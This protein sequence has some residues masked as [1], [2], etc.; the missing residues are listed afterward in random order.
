MS[1][2]SK[3]RITQWLRGTPP[4]RGVLVRGI[5]FADETYVCD[6]DS[7]IFPWAHWS[8]RGVPWRTP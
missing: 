6:F 7:G 2:E 1:D 3:A 5:R 4:V 8:R